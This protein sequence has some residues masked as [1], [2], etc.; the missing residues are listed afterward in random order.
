MANFKLNYTGEEVSNLLDK[1]NNV[2]NDEELSTKNDIDNAIE[3]LASEA[4]VDSALE[5][6]SPATDAVLSA[7]SLNPVQGRT[8]ANNLKKIDR[9]NEPYVTNF[10]ENQQVL[11]CS[12]PFIS[13]INSVAYGFNATPQTTGVVCERLWSSEDGGTNMEGGFD[14]NFGDQFLAETGYT[15]SAAMT[16]LGYKSSSD[17]VQIQTYNN[18]LAA[19][20]SAGYH[21]FYAQDKANGYYYAHRLCVKDSSI[22]DA[23]STE[24]YTS[25][26][27]TYAT[28]HLIL[29]K[30]TI[31][32]YSWNSHVGRTINAV[33]KVT[34]SG[35]YSWSRDTAITFYNTKA[36][37]LESNKSWDESK[38][39][40]YE[41]P[42]Y[43][44]H[45]NANLSSPYQKGI[46]VKLHGPSYN[47]GTP[48]SF[49]ETFAT[50][51]EAAN[52]HGNAIDGSS[53]TYWKGIN[54]L[55]TTS[56]GIVK[57]RWYCKLTKPCRASKMR[58]SFN[59]G[60]SNF[61]IQ[62]SKDGQ[63]W[64]TIQSVTTTTSQGSTYSY[65]FS[66]IDEYQYY[67]VAFYSMTTEGYAQI[68]EFKIDTINIVKFVN[69]LFNINGLGNKQINGT[70][71]SGYNYE[72][73]YNGES[74]D[75]NNNGGATKD[76]MPA[77]SIITSF[78]S[79]T[80][81]EYDALTDKS[82]T[83]LYLIGE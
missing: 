12:L 8:V 37:L 78:W 49:E 65:A 54:I 77:S 29:E 26:G 66:N 34:S 71:E 70:I 57:E 19:C 52:P 40:Y 46:I 44:A 68:Y 3:D 82:A 80:Q 11:N 15:Y 13:D 16:A 56:D 10:D 21:F 33:Y 27:V 55:P 17:P 35:V 58:I 5:S 76:Y 24:P 41:A 81:A 2:P 22:F 38:G 39:Y 63:E 18:V 45:I 36:K 14:G 25:W 59:S 60:I 75:I 72:I 67:G 42:L 61:D 20:S 83:T 74:W 79:G 23:G 32:Y 62:A 7:S 28:L 48:P 1:L 9:Y 43:N 4:Y 50:T 51:Y 73:V 47:N 6:Y 31:F 64:I 69:P 53:S 30:G